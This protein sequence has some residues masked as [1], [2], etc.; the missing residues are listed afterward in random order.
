MR[1]ACTAQTLHCD[2]HPARAVAAEIQTRM[3]RLL[4][5]CFR[6]FVVYQK[7]PAPESHSCLVQRGAA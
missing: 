4:R 3:Y 1:V 7:Q 2:S 5:R 6:R